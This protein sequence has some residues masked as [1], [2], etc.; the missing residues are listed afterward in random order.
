MVLPI[1]GEWTRGQPIPE[2]TPSGSV[3]AGA[4]VFLALLAA[5]MDPSA[6][7]GNQDQV[8]DLHPLPSDGEPTSQSERPEALAFAEAFAV[9]GTLPATLLAATPESVAMVHAGSGGVAADPAGERLPAAANPVPVQEHAVA[10]QSLALSMPAWP[11]ASV[12]GH[13]RAVPAVSAVQPP[14]GEPALPRETSVSPAEFA[15][16]SSTLQHHAARTEG[17]TGGAVERSRTGPAAAPALAVGPVVVPQRSGLPEHGGSL[18]SDETS[19]IAPVDPEVVQVGTSGQLLSTEERMQRPEPQ[20][21]RVAA[22]LS[23]PSGS[24]RMGE[25]VQRADVPGAADLVSQVAESL[26]RGV[27]RGAR[28]VRVRLRPPDLGV[29][30][31]R[32]REIGG[33]LEV[34]LAVGHPDVR[35]ALELGREGLRSALA[36]SGFTVQRIDVQPVTAGGQSSLGTA[37]GGS[38]GSGAHQGPPSDPGM[39]SGHARTNESTPQGGPSGTRTRQAEPTGLVDTWA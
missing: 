2:F 10:A 27:E 13:H 29:V 35:Q 14:P 15:P 19:V 37:P 18:S 23:G 17:S 30:D 38:S 8:T 22:L 31:V 28:E 26:A 5:L 33:R 21:E 9:L 24:L 16:V 12:T 32:V 1:V 25:A 7:T 4:D 3:P 36:A 34:T 11:A 39:A 20:A 6:V